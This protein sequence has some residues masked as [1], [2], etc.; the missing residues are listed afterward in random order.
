[1]RHAR[2]WSIMKW[3]KYF[4]AQISSGVDV[5]H[6]CSSIVW[7]YRYG[8]LQNMNSWKLLDAY[9]W[10]YFSL[11]IIQAPLS[12]YF[13]TDCIDLC[14]CLHQN[15][16]YLKHVHSLNYSL[17]LYKE[18]LY[19]CHS[20]PK[21]KDGSV[22]SFICLSSNNVSKATIICME[23]SAVLVRLGTSGWLPGFGTRWYKYHIR[24][25]HFSI[26]FCLGFN[27][28]KNLNL[29]VKLRLTYYNFDWENK[30]SANKKNRN[31]TQG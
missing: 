21:I 27:A 5:W 19:T 31:S 9:Q 1:M 29:L 18:L 13:Q 25:R 23:E 22:Y 7:M 20:T 28:L 16:A 30:L 4:I 26:S 12:P 17:A 6:G 24:N 2:T 15:V 3:F 11:S 10:K 14:F 8:A